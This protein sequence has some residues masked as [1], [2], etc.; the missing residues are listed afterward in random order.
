MDVQMPEVDGIEATKQIRQ[1]AAYAETPIIGVHLLSISGEKERCLEA[2]CQTFNT[3]LF[4]NGIYS[5]P[6]ENDVIGKT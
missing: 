5:R 1:M 6:L 3:N 4:D 2:G